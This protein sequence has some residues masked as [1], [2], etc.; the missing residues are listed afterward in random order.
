[1][2]CGHRKPILAGVEPEESKRTAVVP[3]VNRHAH[4]QVHVGGGG[5]RRHN[6]GE[7]GES[8]PAPSAA[9]GAERFLRRPRNA[10]NRDDGRRRRADSSRSV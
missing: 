3:D 7:S 6:Q 2:T 10:P 8:N 4:G 1:M 5:R 9:L